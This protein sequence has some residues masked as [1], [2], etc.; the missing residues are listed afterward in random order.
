MVYSVERMDLVGESV[1][2]GVDIVKKSWAV[3]S[4][5]GGKGEFIAA[6]K[7]GGGCCLMMFVN[8]GELEATRTK[9]NEGAELVR[10][11]LRASLY[12]AQGTSSTT[13]F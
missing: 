11:R 3:W 9:L 4:L 13:P 7:K 8:G 5:K 10:I 2:D 6:G 12:C 1:G